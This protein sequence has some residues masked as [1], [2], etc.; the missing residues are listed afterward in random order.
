[1]AYHGLKKVPK[2]SETPMETFNVVWRK[3]N[4]PLCW[5]QAEGW[6][7]SKIEKSEHIIQF[8][9]ISSQKL[10]GKAFF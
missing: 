8:R 2:N 6:S 10:E 1:M 3:G 7:I 9:T 4:V 5:K